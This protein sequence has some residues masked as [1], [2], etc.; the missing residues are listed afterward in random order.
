MHRAAGFVRRLSGALNLGGGVDFLSYSYWTAS[1]TG[2]TVNLAT[3]TA[4]AIGG[5]ISGVEMAAGSQANDIMTGGK[6]SVSN[7]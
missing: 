1:S 7:V 2:V 5:G 3:G 4:T 6:H